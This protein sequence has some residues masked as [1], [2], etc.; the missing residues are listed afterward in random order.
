MPCTCGACVVPP[1]HRHAG[2]QNQMVCSLSLESKR[3]VRSCYRSDLRLV[4]TSATL[5]GEKFSAYF[6]DCP[7]M[8]IPGRCFP[9]DI[10]HSL[11][12]LPPA[13]LAL[14][15]VHRLSEECQPSHSPSVTHPAAQPH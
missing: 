12:V 2:S 4:I 15:Q 5:D 11:E 13:S 1:Q 8:S 3:L 10:V 6:D 9:V 7:V 14:E